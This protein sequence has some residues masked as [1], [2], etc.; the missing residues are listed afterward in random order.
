M[1]NTDT[2]PDIENSVLVLGALY[3]LALIGLIVWLA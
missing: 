2:N 1:M 3:A